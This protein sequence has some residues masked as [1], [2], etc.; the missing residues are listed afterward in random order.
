MKLGN[1]LELELEGGIKIPVKFGTGALEIFC[2]INN[3]DLDFFDKLFDENSGMR[4]I[5]QMKAYRR[6][7]YAGA[8]YAAQSSGKPVDFN[9]YTA[10]DWIDETGG[11]GSEPVKMIIKGL[12]SSIYGNAKTEAQSGEEPGPQSPQP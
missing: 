11:Y 6:A 10:G 8:A 1:Y 9:E 12:I 3:C 7:L 2:D 4:L 5:D